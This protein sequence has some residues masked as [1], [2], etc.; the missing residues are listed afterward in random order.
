MRLVLDT[1]VLIAAFVSRG[2]C[3][4][5]LEHC[6]RAHVLVTSDVIL[7]EFQ[8]KQPGK[9]KVPAATAAT[10]VAL[11]RGRGEVVRPEPLDPPA[12]RDPDGDGVLATAVAGECA[13]IV[14][15]DRDLL[16]L[17]P[18]GEIRVVAP[19]AFWMFEAGLAQA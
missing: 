1:N 10:A 16:A 4:D 7:R 18:F 14:T 19:G 5:L 11:V 2:V 13:C 3:H 8:G 15:G 9:L 12:C 17:D 6:E